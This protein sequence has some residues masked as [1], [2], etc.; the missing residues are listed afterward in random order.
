MP[1]PFLVSNRAVADDD[2]LQHL[3]KRWDCDLLQNQRAQPSTHGL[4]KKERKLML[5]WSFLNLEVG[6]KVHVDLRNKYCLGK[7]VQCRRQR[8]DQL[9]AL[10]SRRKSTCW[11]FIPVVYQA[12]KKHD[13]FSLEMWLCISGF[14]IIYLVFISDLSHLGIRNVV[15]CV[16]YVHMWFTLLLFKFVFTFI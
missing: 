1:F 10:F 13:W 11:C 5:N 8:C 2:G 12:I 6:Q 7:K 9:D 4:P 15:S 14:H 16:L 3:Q